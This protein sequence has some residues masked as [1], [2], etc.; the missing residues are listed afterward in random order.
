VAA[1]TSARSVLARQRE[2][3]AISLRSAGATYDQIAAALGVSAT[4]A[5]RMVRRVLDRT[6]KHTNE[7]ADQLR[8][9]ELRRLDAALVQVWNLMTAA[10][11]A[12]HAG[13][14]P[15]I[16]KDFEYLRLSAID[17]LVKISE[18]RAKLLGLDA[19][20][21]HQ[22]GGDEELPPIKTEAVINWDKATPDELRAIIAIC[23]R[24]TDEPAGG[25]GGAGAGAGSGDSARPVPA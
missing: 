23:G 11:P 7:E 22:H 8:A 21:R 19:P 4:S 3:Q 6:A 9:I 2:S 16:D 15:G 10:A 18:R 12:P 1:K 13:T 25:A 17:R 20:T 5:F 24:L 14:A